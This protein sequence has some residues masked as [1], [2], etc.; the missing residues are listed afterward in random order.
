M[1]TIQK[2]NVTAKD[3]AVIPAVTVGIENSQKKAVV[4]ICHGFGEHS[5]SY[6]EFAE[7]LQK[8]GYASIIPDQRGHGTPPEGAKNWYGQIPNY[9]CFVDDVI[10]LSEVVR[11]MA[12]ET[13]I[14]LY[15]HSMGGNIV[16]NTVLNLPAQE[17]S[18]FNCAVLEAPW[19]A[20]YKPPTALEVFMAK[21][22]TPIAPSFRFERKLN[23]ALLSSDTERAES[24]VKD[25]LYH[26]FISMRMVTGILGGCDYAMENA[27]RLPIPVYLAYADN[28]LVVSNEAILQFAEKAGEIVTKKE[29]DSN[30]AIHNDRIREQYISDMIA[31]FDSHV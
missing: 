6:I 12:P 20:L 17:A 4:I 13:P 11:K 1:S 19:F 26:G 14:V 15:G 25:P 18:L 7:D 3:G 23:S 16:I 27:A 8:A 24:Y 2:I 9:Q 21:I 10:S 30:H 28:E 5:G 22:L 31:F 29:Y